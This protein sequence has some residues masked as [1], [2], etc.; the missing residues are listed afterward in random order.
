MKFQPSEVWAVWD[1]GILRRSNG[2]ATT[3]NQ[4]PRFTCALELR[5]KFSCPADNVRTAS[6]KE[7][8]KP[9]PSKANAAGLYIATGIWRPWKYDKPFNQ[10]ALAG[11]LSQA[12]EGSL[13]SRW[14]GRRYYQHQVDPETPVEEDTVGAMRR[15]DKVE[16]KFCGF[17]GHQQPPSVEDSSDNGT[18]FAGR[19]CRRQCLTTPRTQELVLTACSPLGRGFLSGK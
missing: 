10:R 17:V 12:V 9:Q 14:N 16:I 7:A 18:V 6:T 4:S 13:S 2:L 5:H 19:E 11:I 1:V 15:N 3:R 8:L